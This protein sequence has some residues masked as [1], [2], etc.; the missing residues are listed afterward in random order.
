MVGDVEVDFRRV[1][2]TEIGKRFKSD[3]ERRITSKIM[4]GE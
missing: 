2:I 1:S 4:N 3:D